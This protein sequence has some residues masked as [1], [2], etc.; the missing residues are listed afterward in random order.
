MWTS[1]IMNLSVLSLVL[2]AFY[3]AIN[4]ATAANS[5][6]EIPDPS[7]LRSISGKE[8]QEARQDLFKSNNMLWLHLRSPEVLDHLYG[9]ATSNK[10]IELD[11]VNSYHD[12]RNGAE[13]L[14][15]EWEA[16][17]AGYKRRIDGLTDLCNIEKYRFS[18]EIQELEA[19]LEPL[20]EKILKMQ[21]ILEYCSDSNNPCYEIK[22]SLSSQ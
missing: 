7:K 22:K 4:A 17:R 5:Q 21:V 9:L 3:S 14:K 18:K 2:M 13:K 6:H 1:S 11:R 20:D 12:M 19:K 10:K 16:K 8:S 15:A